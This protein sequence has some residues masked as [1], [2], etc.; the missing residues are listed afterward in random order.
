[1]L[2]GDFEDLFDGILGGWDAETVNLELNSYYKLFNCKYYP[3]PII[4]KETF[5]K[6]LQGLVKKEC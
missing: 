6:E 4:N 5:R 1:M 2:L 3:A